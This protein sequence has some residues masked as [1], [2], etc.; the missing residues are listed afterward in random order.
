VDRICRLDID[1]R[2]R[3]LS[4]GVAVRWWSRARGLWPGDRWPAYDI[5]LLPRCAA[6]HTFGMRVPIDVVFSDGHGRV[7][8]VRSALAPWR[9]AFDRSACSTWEMRAGA[10]QGLGL[11]RGMRMR[12][13]DRARGATAV[14]FL[15]AALLVVMPLAFAVVEI[16]QLATARHVLQHAVNEAARQAAVS[17]PSESALRRSLGLGMLPLFVPLDA[18]AP[19]GPSRDDAAAERLSAAVGLE[20]LARAYGETFRPDLTAVDLETLDAVGSV[21][22]LRVRYCREMF[23]PLV[24]D[25]IAGVLRLGTVSPFE[26]AC[27]ARERMPLD[28]WALVLRRGGRLREADRLPE[29]PPTDA[30]DLPSIPPPPDPGGGGGGGGRDGG[31]TGDTGDTMDR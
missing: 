20:G 11:R 21:Q 16:A 28:A 5:L 17:D 1:G 7:T 19:F 8:S 22:R 10:A 3:D 6:V 27:L 2:P 14:E 13:V 15:I 18:R 12:A 29:L 24:R 9:V 30:G 4:V 23:M 31:D 26:Q 25:A